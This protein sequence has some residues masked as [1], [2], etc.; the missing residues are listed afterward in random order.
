MLT[1][2]QVSERLGITAERVRQL[3]RKGRVPSQK[4]GR[5]YFIKESDLGLLMHRKTGRPPM[6][7]GPQGRAKAQK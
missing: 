6:K 4:A 7:T 3:I 5:D 1:T 2:N